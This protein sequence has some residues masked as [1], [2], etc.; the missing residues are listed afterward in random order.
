LDWKC[1][2]LLY[3][4]NEP[5]LAGVVHHTSFAGSPLPPLESTKLLLNEAFFGAVEGNW[6]AGGEELRELRAAFE[7][8]GV[9]CV[10]CIG[11]LMRREGINPHDFDPERRE[12]SLRLLEGMIDRA[13]ACG[14]KQVVLCSGS[15]VAR[16][17]RESA[18]EL[19]AE[20]LGRLCR[21]AAEQ[22]PG[23]PLWLCLE[24]FDR[25]L[26]QKRLLGPTGET[27]ALVAAVARD[28]FNI[29]ITL[30]LS[31]V[32]QLGEDP[33]AAVRAARRHL[34]H[35]HIANCGL[36]PGYPSLFGDSH[37]RFGIPGGAVTMNDLVAFLD[38]VSRQ[39]YLRRRTPTRL[40]VIS[41]EIKP[42]ARE[43]PWGLV[44][45]GQRAL[46]EAVE[47]INHGRLE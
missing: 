27:A 1:P 22:A 31:H 43:D 17:Q 16:E 11:G 23:E 44:A 2:I 33:R 32:K 38:E 36:D 41:F 20:S 9:E 6:T 5:F 21:Y 39:G 30:D 37:P 26:D 15:D 18:K 45:N 12:R 34:I 4:R 14:A 42:V 7:T 29:G 8:A 3:L 25:E 46:W 28:H 19:L 10:Y 47:R 24:H 13:Y 40:P 35:V